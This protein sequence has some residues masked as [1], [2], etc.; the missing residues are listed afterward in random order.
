[1]PSY[2][3]IIAAVLMVLSGC[4][5]NAEPT[6]SWPCA[7]DRECRNGHCCHPELGVCTLRPIQCAE[8]CG[9]CPP[10]Q[11]A[12]ECPECPICPDVVCGPCDCVTCEPCV[13]E[14]CEVCEEYQA[15]SAW[16]GCLTVSDMHVT[17]LM[18]KD[19]AVLFP[20]IPVKL[21]A[22]AL[23]PEGL[24]TLKFSAKRKKGKGSVQKMN[25]EVCEVS[26]RPFRCFW[27]PL[28]SGDYEIWAKMKSKTRVS[29]ESAKIKVQVGL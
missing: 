29:V 7:H 20:G 13:C 23:V 5:V 21:K 3:M 15:C 25:D 10:C 9:V 19:G 2:R 1:M 14:Q 27:T 22:S 16:T 17:M 28:E 4:I 11:D 24:E 8:T 12:P 26:E 6:D 18:P